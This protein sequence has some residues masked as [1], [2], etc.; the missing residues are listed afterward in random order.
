MALMKMENLFKMVNLNYQQLEIDKFYDISEKKLGIKSYNEKTKKNEYKLVKGLFYKGKFPI[1]K[2]VS[3]DGSI[4]LKGNEFHKVYD[5]LK[6]KYISLNSSDEINIF[7][8]NH[9]IVSAFI[10]KTK[11]VEDIVDLQI[12]DNQNYFGNG[13]LNHNTGGEA[14]NFYSSTINRVTKIDV[15]KDAVETIGQQIRVRNY[16]NK[17]SIPFRD[18]EMNLYFKGGFKPD[19]EYLD[20]IIKFNIFKQG[21][22]WFTNDEYNVK[23]NGRVKVQEW[24]NQN[25]EA[26]EKMKNQVDELLTKET[27]LDINNV[28]PE[29]QVEEEDSPEIREDILG[30][31]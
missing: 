4:I 28:D 7:L 16:K 24:L 13:I 27:S 2:V 1:Y 19:D 11:E 14:P 3:K 18:A 30:D 12:E 25:S 29:S 15:I 23:L 26:F 6:K 31:E 10:Q 22:A 20:F 17:T 21:G 8:E 5:A 9:E